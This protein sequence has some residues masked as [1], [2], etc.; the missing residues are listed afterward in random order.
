MFAPGYPIPSGTL[1][2]IAFYGSNET[3]AGLLALSMIIL[4]F[5][6][7]R[8]F[9]KPFPINLIAILIS[10]PVAYY[11]TTI[12]SGVYAAGPIISLLGGI[13]GLI[14]TRRL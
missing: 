13:L 3:I 1:A 9:V 12:N 5:C 14:Q 7:L 10:V 2:S 11:F 6:S 4:I 8:A